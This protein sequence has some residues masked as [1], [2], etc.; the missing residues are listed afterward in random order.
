[1]PVKYI[2]IVSNPREQSSVGIFDNPDRSFI[3]IPLTTF[4]V[5]EDVIQLGE[6]DI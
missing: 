1:M 5:P 6:I 2:F 3:N 4:Q